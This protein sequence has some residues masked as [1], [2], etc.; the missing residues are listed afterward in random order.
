MKAYQIY[1][2]LSSELL[3]EMFMYF[4]ASDRGFYSGVISS[5]AKD[6]KLRPQFVTKKP[7]VD[8]IA[9]CHK[10]LKLLSNDEIGEH[11]F[12]TWFMKAHSEVLAKFCDEAGI[13]HDGQGTVSGALPETL[14]DEKVAKAVDV[15]FDSFNPKLIT[16]YLHVFNI[17]RIDGWPKLTEILSSDERLEW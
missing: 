11:L 8:Q 9:W 17:Q 2:N 7:V 3:E 12:Q 10:A 6:R 1:Q 16:L 4:R 14:E 13:E 5:L 15:L